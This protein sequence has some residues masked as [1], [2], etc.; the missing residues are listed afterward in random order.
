MNIPRNLIENV[1]Y[2]RNLNRASRVTEF[3]WPGQCEEISFS[4]SEFESC[5]KSLVEEGYFQTRPCIPEPVLDRLIECIK[6]VRADRHAPV[7][8]LLYDDY[9]EVLASLGGLL[10]ELLGIGFLIVPDEP[11]VYLIRTGNDEGGAAPHRDTLRSHD[12]YNEDGMP[13]VINLWIPIT[14]ATSLNS[15]MHVIPAHADVDYQTPQSDQDLPETLDTRLLQ[16]VR[17]LPAKAGSVIG[18]STE[19]IHWGGYS[20]VLAEYPRLSFAMYFQRAD[21]RLFHRSAMPVPFRLSFDY[22][23]YLI[24]KE[25]RDR[26]G[27]E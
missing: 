5:K 15:C 2:W 16:S 26:R 24:E 22:R 17:A 21:A 10:R 9:F 8:A 7:Y 1:D 13:A 18:W 27:R 19:L 11:D 12:M 14:D 20:S 4:D 6:A 23:L 25:S 3:P